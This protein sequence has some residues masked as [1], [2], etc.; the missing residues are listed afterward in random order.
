VNDMGLAMRTSIRLRRDEAR[1]VTRLFIPGQ[2]LMGG[3]ETRSSHAVARVLALSESE[4]TTALQDMY[5][6]FDSRHED[7]TQIFEDHAQRMV[8]YITTPITPQRRLLIGAVFTHEYSI[9]GAAIFNPSIVAHPDQGNTAPGTLRFVMSVRAVGEGHHSSIGFRTGEIDALG[10]VQLDTA[11]AFPLVGTLGPSGFNR[12]LFHSLLLDLGYDGVFAT[13]VLNSVNETFNVADLET[14][15]LKLRYQHDTRPHVATTAELLRLIAACCYDVSFRP[16]VDISR[17]VLWPAAPNEQHGM[18]DARFVEMTAPGVSRY[19]ASYVAF[20]GHSVSQQ[21]LETQDFTS[22]R[23]SPL[24]GGAARNKGLAFFPRQIR[25]RFAAMSRGD[26]EN[27]AVAF[28]DDLHRWDEA[29]IIQTPTYSW[30]VVQLGN[31]GSP[32]ELDEGWLV[33]THGVGPMRTYG[34]GAILLDLEDPTK[35]IGRLPRPLLTASIEEQDGYVPNAVYSCGSLIHSG[36]LYI[37]YGVADESISC[38][39]VQVSE[40]VDAFVPVHSAEVA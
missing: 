4:V 3:S 13:S 22:F 6:R 28:S 33:M 5:L 38:A 21:L 23:S 8:D 2:D 40:L 15:M 31:C 24:A 16:N 17:R 25:G 1:V 34:I 11:H 37:P 39:R 18:E 14:A 32:I 29:T 20:D 35:V 36:Q 26:R 30:E 7:L 10:H 12:S 9:E 19:V 27:N